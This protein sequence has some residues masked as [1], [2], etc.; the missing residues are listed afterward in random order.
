M[1]FELGQ[2]VATRTAISTGV[3][4][5]E[6]VRRH[7]CEDWGDLEDS[8]KRANYA[9]LQLGGRLVSKYIAGGHSFYVITEADRSATTIML[10]E[11]Y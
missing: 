2:V 11:D 5:V 7:H 10:V 6:L 1:Q 9:A 3:N 4:L 8:D